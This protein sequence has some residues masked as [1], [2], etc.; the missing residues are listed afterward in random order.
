MIPFLPNTSTT[1][2]GM[3]LLRDE[4]LRQVLAGL[5][6]AICILD[7]KGV[8]VYAN[9]AF[10]GCVS[11]VSAEVFARALHE[12]APMELAEGVCGDLQQV[13]RGQRYDRVEARMLP[14]GLRSLRL[15]CYPIRCQS[16]LYAVLTLE[17]QGPF[18][19]ALSRP[20]TL[21]P[22]DESNMC[23][24][25]I[26]EPDPAIARLAALL[27]D[28]RGYSVRWQTDLT[29]ARRMSLA[30]SPEVLLVDA[31]CC[32]EN[33]A[34][35]LEELLSRW[36][37]RLVLSTTGQVPE[38]SEEIADRLSAVVKKPFC[39]ETLLKAILQGR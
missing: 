28:R 14:T 11:G 39:L 6:S 16:C 9:P 18:V 4:G 12:I 3:E 13:M 17:D 10:V 26:I 25:L 27:L 5:P 24:T 7:A 15:I 8:C 21:V 32:E 37:A 33:R 1:D 19:P 36:P 38:V 2:S 23:H 30:Q 35:Q 34:E 20:E 22:E 29:L 31:S